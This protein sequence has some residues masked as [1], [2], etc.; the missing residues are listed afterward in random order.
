MKNVLMY[1]CGLILIRLNCGQVYVCLPTHVRICG[2]FFFKL[3]TFCFIISSKAYEANEL[4]YL[5]VSLNEKI[6]HRVLQGSIGDILVLLHI[7][8]KDYI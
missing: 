8:Q 2:M 3:V 4:G 6:L 1:L 5:N 7:M